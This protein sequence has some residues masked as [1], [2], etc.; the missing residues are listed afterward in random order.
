MPQLTQYPH[1]GAL[2]PSEAVTA[3]IK[4]CREVPAE[5]ESFKEH[6]RRLKALGL[7]DKERVGDTL[8]FFHMAKG[9][10]IVPSKVMRTIG[11]ATKDQDARAALTERLWEC[12]PVLFK[13]VIERLA[14]RVYPTAE[15]YTFLDSS[16]YSGTHLPRVQLDSW[17]WLCRGLSVFKILGVALA[18]D[19]RGQ[20]MVERVKALNLEDYLEEDEPEEEPT[21]VNDES[22]ADE[23]TASSAKASEAVAAAPPAQAPAAAAS[24]A[25]EATTTG[26]YSSPRGHHPAVSPAEFAGHEHFSDAVAKE[27]TRR[28]EEWWAQQRHHASKP[29]LE[30]FGLNNERWIENSEETLYR[31]AVA[32]AL[33]FRLGGTRAQL[34][35]AY[36]ALDAG[37]VLDGLYYGHAP[38]VLSP[39]VDPRALMWASLVARRHAESP[40]L[41]ARLEQ[42]ETA[43][44][45]FELLEGALGRGLFRLELFWIMRAL[46]ELGALRFEDLGDYTALPN[47][48]VR[49][50]L[51]RL[52]YLSSP[53]AHDSKSLIRAAA[54]ARRATGNATPADEVLSSFASAAGCSYGCSHSKRCDY[55][56]RERADL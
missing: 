13:T 51:F 41:Q 20:S 16:A 55:A 38:E 49:D 52:G 1:V 54:A 11:S 24:P 9:D 50:T 8:R 32:A 25:A 40:G 18:L 45:A 47:R 28:L 33:I 48:T 34:R 29:S 43:A 31:L 19:E 5:G 42:Q 56:C 22:S 17:V 44:A 46:Q 15:L 30:D 53:Y 26:Q 35:N 10:R 27:T 21:P 7:W 3:L 36:E 39:Q 2:S 12:N 14:E 37:G 4:L 23:A 6:R